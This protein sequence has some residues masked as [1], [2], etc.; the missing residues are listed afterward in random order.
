MLTTI[1]TCIVNILI[2]GP[3]G[4]VGDPGEQGPK[5]MKVHVLNIHYY[6]DL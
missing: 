3:R 2:Q 1:L 4:P 5:G 6:N